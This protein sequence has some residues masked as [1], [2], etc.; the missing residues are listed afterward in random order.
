MGTFSEMGDVGSPGGGEGGEPSQ[1]LLPTSLLGVDSDSIL[2]SH[3][4][5]Q[6]PDPFCRV[7]GGFLERR[8]PGKNGEVPL[9]VCPASSILGRTDTRVARVRQN[10]R[11]RMWRR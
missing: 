11:P 8:T 9:E 7:S 5:F 10:Q 2:F 6:K 1:C 4:S 3:R